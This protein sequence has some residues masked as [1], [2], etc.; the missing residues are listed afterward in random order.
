LSQYLK[1]SHMTHLATHGARYVNG[2]CVMWLPARLARR[3][4]GAIVGL[5]TAEV[6]RAPPVDGC[7]S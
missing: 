4:G 2:R 7:G 5:E 1:D 3:P 6:Y